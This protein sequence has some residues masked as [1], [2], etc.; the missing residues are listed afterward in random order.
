MYASWMG[1]I[2]RQCYLVGKFLLMLIVEQK[3]RSSSTLMVENCEV[4]PLN[5]PLCFK[6]LD[7][8]PLV[9]T[10]KVSTSITIVGETEEVELYVADTPCQVLLGRDLLRAIALILIYLRVLILVWETEPLC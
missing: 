9:V 4:M 1:H 6:L 3:G 10:G 5:E 2:L 7:D 8:T